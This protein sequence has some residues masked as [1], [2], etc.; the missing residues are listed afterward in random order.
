[1]KGELDVERY[2]SEGFQAE[3]EALDIGLDTLYIPIG[4]RTREL[5][6]LLVGLRVIPA[7]QRVFHKEYGIGPLFRGKPVLNLTH[8]SAAVNMQD[9]VESLL[10]QHSL[11]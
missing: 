9:A 2:V 3:Q 8:Y 4:A 5:W 11:K 7:E 6:D 10:S 1:M